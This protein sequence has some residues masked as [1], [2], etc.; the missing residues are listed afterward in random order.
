MLDII[1]DVTR[2]VLWTLASVALI[3]FI[4]SGG[5]VV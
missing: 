1:I 3:L 2:A 4:L 5:S